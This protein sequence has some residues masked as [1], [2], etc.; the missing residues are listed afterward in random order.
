MD[1]QLEHNGASLQVQ[2]VRGVPVRGVGK[3]QNRET[4]VICDF[5]AATLWVELL[6]R[7]LK[8]LS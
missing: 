3:P 5:E 6:T 2:D 1:E 4:V 8:R 7:K